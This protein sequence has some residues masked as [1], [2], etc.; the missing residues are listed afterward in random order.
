MNEKSIEEGVVDSIYYDIWLNSSK[1]NEKIPFFIPDTIVYKYYRPLNWYFT[2]INGRIN[3]KKKENI[4]PSK[5][6]ESFS[7]E[8]G[9]SKIV[10]YY[11][12]YDHQEIE[13]IK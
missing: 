11:I 5:I 4:T 10:A 3:K 7:K 9:P 6:K 2:S 13:F 12:Y 8:I 1:G